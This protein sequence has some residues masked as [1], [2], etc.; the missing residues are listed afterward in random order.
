MAL[1]REL[2]GV[3]RNMV[4]FTGISRFRA[5]RGGGAAATEVEDA[6]A[7]VTEPAAPGYAWVC[8]LYGDISHLQDKPPA[9]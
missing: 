8:E 9:M 2:D 5:N 1:A 6:T 4:R 3:H 7:L